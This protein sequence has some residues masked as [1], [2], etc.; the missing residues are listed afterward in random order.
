MLQ[1][2]T[3]SETFFECVVKKILPELNFEKIDL[4]RPITHTRPLKILGFTKPA[5]PFNLE[6]NEQFRYS[7]TIYFQDFTS[8]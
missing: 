3:L 1:N 2:R 6:L 4:F 7:N 5:L 8:I